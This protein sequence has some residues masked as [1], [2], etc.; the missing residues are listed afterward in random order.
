MSLTGA[1]T[2]TKRM[3]NRVHCHT[4][5]RRTDTPPPVAAGLTKLR[6]HAVFVTDNTD[7]CIALCIHTAELAGRQTDGNILTFLCSNQS[8]CTGRADKLTA[9]TERQLDVMNGETDRNCRQRKCIANSRRC[10]FAR[11]NLLPNS[12]ALGSNDVALFAVSISNQSD[13][14]AAERIILNRL[15][16]SRNTVLV[17]AEVN[18]TILSLVTATLMTYR[19]TSACATTSFPSMTVGKALLGFIGCQFS[20]HQVNTCARTF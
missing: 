8:A 19:D 9:T 5:Y 11:H 20:A 15:D 12:Q 13:V 1:F 16:S 7:C 17:T 2:T 10:I 4:T 6:V 14:C 3:V 18:F